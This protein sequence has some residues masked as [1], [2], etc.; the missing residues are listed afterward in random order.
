M[1]VNTLI[2]IGGCGLTPQ[3]L[4]INSLIWN[5]RGISKAPTVRRLRK[6][7]QLHRLSLICVPEPF[8][9]ADRLEA[10]QFRLWMDHAISSQSGKIWVF[11]STIFSV[12]IMIDMGQVIH[13]RVSHALFPK[14]VFV[15]Y[16]YT[17][18]SMHIRED[19]WDAL[20]SFADGH[21]RP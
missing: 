11:W 16:V 7:I 17:S 5:V 12:E 19:L 6:L 10:T 4:M 13:C 3:T 2:L 20:M 21:G 9:F 8:L 1:I 15:S 14:H 18:C